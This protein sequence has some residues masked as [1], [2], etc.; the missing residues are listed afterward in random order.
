MCLLE[1][2]E[3]AKPKAILLDVFFPEAE[4]KVQAQA[5]LAEFTKTYPNSP[6]KADANQIMARLM[7]GK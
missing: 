5:A 6:P 2:L 1:R 3:T 4:Q 7:A